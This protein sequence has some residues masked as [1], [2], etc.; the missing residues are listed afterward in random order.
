MMGML[1]AILKTRQVILKAMNRKP[2][3]T[4]TEVKVLDK[5]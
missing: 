2:A 4:M 1:V 5:G 3:M